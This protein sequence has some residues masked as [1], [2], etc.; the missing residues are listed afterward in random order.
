MVLCVHYIYN[1][2][3]VCAQELCTGSVRVQASCCYSACT[4]LALYCVNAYIVSAHI[5]YTSRSDICVTDSLPH[6]P[7]VCFPGNDV[8]QACG[9]GW[10]LNPAV[11]SVSVGGGRAPQNPGRG[12]RAS[13]SMCRPLISRVEGLK[14]GR[15][16]FHQIQDKQDIF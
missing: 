16:F 3:V 7:L 9:G 5:T 8:M 2:L 14:N 4:R 1:C 11:G 15:K 6:C 10:L 12:G 13:R